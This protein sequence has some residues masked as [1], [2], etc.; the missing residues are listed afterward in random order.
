MKGKVLSAFVIC[1]VVAIVFSSISINN[2]SVTVNGDN[3]HVKE[4]RISSPSA[5]NDEVNPNHSETTR[6]SIISLFSLFLLIA[7]KEFIKN[8]NKKEL[9]L[10]PKGSLPF[11]RNFIRSLVLTE[12]RF[13]RSETEC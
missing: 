6:N 10:R 4:I 2:I 11:R 5:T 12:R 7:V 1:C 13:A 3:S 8:R 9:R